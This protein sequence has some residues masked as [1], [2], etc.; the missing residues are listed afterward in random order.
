MPK[1]KGPKPAHLSRALTVPGE[2]TN[3]DREPHYREQTRISKEP[4][5]PSFDELMA[6]LRSPAARAEMR[7]MAKERK[8]YLLTDY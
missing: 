7:Q 5:E 3:A 4:R 6:T 8:D 2:P 1:R